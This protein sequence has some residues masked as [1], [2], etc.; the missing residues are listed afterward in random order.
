MASFPNPFAD[1]SSL[2]VF[3]N[4]P[5]GA[6]LQR[7]KTPHRAAKDKGIPVD[8]PKP[9]LVA[10]F[11]IDRPD[12]EP[13]VD[14]LDQIMDLM[15]KRSHM[16]ARTSKDHQKEYEKLDRL[17]REAVTGFSVKMVI[18]PLAWT[19]PSFTL[20]AVVWA[21]E[22]LDKI[23]ADCK[24][25]KY[26]LSKVVLSARDMENQDSPLLEWSFETPW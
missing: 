8:S 10:T 17:V 24:E 7:S 21:F 9:R 3:K 22:E 5:G 19:D 15:R 13:F 23:S 2:P 1:P 25:L 16:A 18:D 12:K 4:P 26:V 14:G 20:K 6:T 11:A